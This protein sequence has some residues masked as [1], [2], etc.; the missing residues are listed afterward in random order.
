MLGPLD[1]PEAGREF[2]TAA[3]Q[4]T[5]VQA[6]TALCKQKPADPLLW[7][8]DWLQQHNPSAP[9]VLAAQ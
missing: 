8:A 4:P 9:S 1:T 5:L 7:L 3:V 6:L 2:I